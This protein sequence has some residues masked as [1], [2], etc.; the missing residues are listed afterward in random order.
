M[1]WHTVKSEN[2]CIMVSRSH[3]KHRGSL[4]AYVNMEELESACGEPRSSKNSGA[5]VVDVGLKSTVSKLASEPE[6]WRLRLPGGKG[7]CR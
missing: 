4:S 6:L 2:G 5:V 3:P 1:T 7:H